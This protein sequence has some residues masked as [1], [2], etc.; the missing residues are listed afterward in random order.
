[1]KLMR[2]S[3]IA[4]LL[5]TLIPM[6]GDLRAQGQAGALRPA[7]LGG[8]M[9]DFTLPALQGGDYGI[10]KLKG[11]NVLL[12]FPRGKSGAGDEWCQICHYQ[13]AELAELEKTLHL[14]EKYNLEI[15]YVLPYDA[16]TAKHWAE[17]FPEQMAVIDGWKNPPETASA[18]QKNFAQRVKRFLPKEFA[19]KKGEVAVPFPILV[20]ADRRVSKGLGLFSTNWDGVQA[21]QNVPTMF[22]VDAS[23]VVQFKYMS[24]ITWDRPNGEYF[25][26]IFDK[27][28]LGK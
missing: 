4:L 26:R 18:G 20:D 10:A 9:P 15:L 23:G 27:M 25:V 8:P 6:T 24:Q 5:F 28:I 1:M 16:A 7:F 19:F 17:I 11:K 14:K 22:L 3:L 12:V 13:Y 2:L 21:D